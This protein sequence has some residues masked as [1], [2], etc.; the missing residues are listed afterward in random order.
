MCMSCRYQLSENKVTIFRKVGNAPEKI[1]NAP[2]KV[3]NDPK[4]V[5]NAPEKIS[6]DFENYIPLFEEAEVTIILTKMV[7]I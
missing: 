5:G 1:S 6:S 3:S 7:R 4:K 2:E